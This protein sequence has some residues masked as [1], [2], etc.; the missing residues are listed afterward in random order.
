MQVTAHGMS[1]RTQL[2]TLYLGFGADERL[3][4]RVERRRRLRCAQLPHLLNVVA[5]QRGA[6]L[7]SSK[8]LLM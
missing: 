5:R 3:L 8:H 7:I 2:S 6:C 4:Q 1:R